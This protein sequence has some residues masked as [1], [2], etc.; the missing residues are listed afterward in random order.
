MNFKTY[1]AKLN[2]VAQATFT[3]LLEAEDA[4]KKAEAKQK[5]FSRVPVNDYEAQAKASRARADFLEAESKLRA[6]KWNMDSR[7]NEASAIRRELA[8]AV[9]D[10]YSADPE[11]LDTAT[12]ELLKSSILKSSEYARLANRAAQAGNVTMLRLIGKYAADA[13]E[14]T[15]KQYGTGDHVAK[16]LRAVAYQCNR[17][18]GKDHLEAFDAMIDIFRRCMKNPGLIPSWAEFTDPIINQF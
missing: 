17:N 6:V 7:I 5:T 4:F 16:E 8:A 18:T 12:L 9:E 15:A 10:A 11:A 13:A 1:A 3:E 2:D 14:E